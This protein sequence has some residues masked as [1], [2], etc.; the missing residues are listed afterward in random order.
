M[1]EVLPRRPWLGAHRVHI[2]PSRAGAAFG[3]LLL[4]LWIA[5]VNYQLSLGYALT[6]LAGACAVAD[7]LFASRNLAGLALSATPGAPVAAGMPATFELCL[8]E[9]SARAR[10][11]INVR[12]AGSHTE[13]QAD[14]D[15]DGRW[16][17]SI[18]VPAVRRGWLAAPPVQLSASFPLG[19][20]YAWCHWLPEVRV[21]VYPTPEQPAPALPDAAPGQHGEHARDSQ[22][23]QDSQDSGQ[24]ELAGVRAYQPGDALQ[25]LAWRQIARHDGEAGDHLY[26]KQFEASPR[27]A[28]A[29]TPLLF[30]FHALPDALDTEAR[31]S[32]LSAWVLQAESAGRPYGLRLAGVTLMPATGA[33]HQAACLRALAL[34]GQP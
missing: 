16:C 9:R 18:A 24:R 20:F 34:Y 30:D 26:T 3:A 15:A 27:A 23:S 21:L 7:M 6:C 28:A 29:A 14:I 12:A 13:L 4:A 32:R 2:R 10:H 22:N 5:A 11:A 25:R 17:A 31:L 1:S 33:A 19:L 8:L